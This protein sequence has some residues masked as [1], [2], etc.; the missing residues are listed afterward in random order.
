MG[1]TYS[2][3]TKAAVLAALLTGQSVGEIAKS[4]RVPAATIR[5]WNSRQGNGGGVANV[6]TQKKE[7]IGELLV[8]YLGELLVTLKAQAK[9][10]RQIEWLKE[11]PA[12]EVAVLH[13]VLADKGIRLLEALADNEAEGEDV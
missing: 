5:S 2:E 9:F 6:A 7:L 1:R 12:S 11:Q 13:G 10:A 3:E 4:Y 8:D